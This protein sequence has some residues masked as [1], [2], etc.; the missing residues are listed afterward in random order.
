[1]SET[2]ADGVDVEQHACNREHT[3][4][5]P[6]RRG[7]MQ[8]GCVRLIVIHVFAHSST[9]ERRE[10]V[11]ETLRNSNFRYVRVEHETSYA[12]KHMTSCH[13][14]YMYIPAMYASCFPSSDAIMFFLSCEL[15]WIESICNDEDIVANNIRDTKLF[16]PDYANKSES[17]V[18][19]CACA[20]ACGVACDDVLQS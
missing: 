15:V 8:S 4:D 6:M 20:Y 16:S 14:T 5:A 10:M 11:A 2:C 9:R 3:Y 12:A 18:A 19:A 13:H 1:M 7:A 17:C